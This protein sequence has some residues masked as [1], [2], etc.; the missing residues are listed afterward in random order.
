[1]SFNY[2]KVWKEFDENEISHSMTHY[3]LAIAVLTL[4]DESTRATDIAE[5]LGVSRNAVSIQLKGLVKQNLVRID[6]ENGLHLTKKGQV[7]AH[8]ISS[9]RETMRIFL[10]EVLGVSKKNAL[11]DS[12]KIEHLLSDETGAALIKLVQFIR[13]DKKVVLN[14]LKEYQK[15]VVK[16]NPNIGC[17]LCENIWT[18]EKSLA[19]ASPKPEMR[20]MR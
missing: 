5:H 15:T 12:C 19:K 16:C 2:D 13:S 9:K 18:I 4:E 20:A 17:G 11:G 3:I 10:E 6:K 14:F 8:K 7:L 1:M